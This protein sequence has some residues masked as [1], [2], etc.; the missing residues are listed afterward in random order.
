MMGGTKTAEILLDDPEVVETSAE[1]GESTVQ[2]SGT[3]FADGLNANAWGLT[4]EGARSIAASL[5]GAD[6]TAGHP[7]VVGYGFT[8]SI[9]ED[10]GKPIGVVEDT[11]VQEVASAMMSDVGGGYTAEYTATVQSPSYAEDFRNGLMIGGDY[12]VSIGITA[13]DDD[14]VCSI[15]GKPW[16][17]S[18][19]SRG[20]EVDGDI[21]GPLYN[22]GNGDHLAVVYVP[23]W[24]EA[25][26]EVNANA[27]S[28][29]NVMFARSADEF[30][31]QPR[32]SGENHE[33]A[34]ETR[35]DF[36]EGDIV[37]WQAIRDAYGEVVHNPDEPQE[38]VMVDLHEMS[39]GQLEPTG[40]TLTAGV[41]DLLHFDVE[42]AS[43][44]EAS[45]SEA[46]SLQVAIEKS[47]ETELQL[48]L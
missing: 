20:E 13:D 45:G 40:D 15:T 21:A 33:E 30:F 31:G 37:R 11:A 28:D 25:D 4:E 7:A 32:N 39:G 29:A 8:R 27:A 46:S 23:A 22:G 42:E 1:G 5:E 35:P 36:E 34:F 41:D 43:V 47:E 17:E 18:Q 19:Y 9:H 24:G 3:M 48:E 10:R 16:S 2:L 6:L 14:A 12:G 38:I 44:S 26:A